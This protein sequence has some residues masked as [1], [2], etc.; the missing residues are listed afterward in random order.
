MTPG[1]TDPLAMWD[2]MTVEVIEL[3]FVSYLCLR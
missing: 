3:F 1:D 2:I